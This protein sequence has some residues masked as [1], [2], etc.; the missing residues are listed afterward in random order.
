MKFFKPKKVTLNAST[1]AS[2]EI[3]KLI[4][5]W[6]FN[7]EDFLITKA[8]ITCANEGHDKAG[9]PMQS[10][11]VQT[12]GLYNGKPC[13]LEAS[14]L[15]IKADSWNLADGSSPTLTINKSGYPLILLQ[16]KSAGNLS[17]YSTDESVAYKFRKM[18][19]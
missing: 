17:F 8:M 2:L 9:H 1:I 7:S 16:R 18:M 12:A 4:T 10:M 6:L 5:K 3:A 13:D 11:R 19:S 14:F 15:I